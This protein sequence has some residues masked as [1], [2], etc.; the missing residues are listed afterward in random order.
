MSEFFFR[1]GIPEFWKL[2]R[3]EY[4]WHLALNTFN[5]CRLPLDT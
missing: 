1:D 3:T 2:I 5:T 4:H